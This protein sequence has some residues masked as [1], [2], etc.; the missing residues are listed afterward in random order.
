M[1]GSNVVSLNPVVAVPQPFYTNDDDDD[2]GS[3][4]CPNEWENINPNFILANMKVLSEALKGGN[5]KE[6][7]KSPQ[8]SNWEKMNADQ[9]N[10][11][12]AWFNLL[13][14]STKS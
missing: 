8:Y 2:L 9:K 6:F 12:V 7:F 1:S 14:Q 4:G 10:K 11:A 13:D 3:S 5:K